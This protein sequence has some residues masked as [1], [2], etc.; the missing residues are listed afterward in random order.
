MYSASIDEIIYTAAHR[1][2][3]L[4][5]GASAISRTQVYPDCPLM[6]SA[7]IKIESS[8]PMQQGWLNNLIDDHTPNGITDA[9]SFIL[10]LLIE[11]G[12]V[13]NYA[14]S[15]FL[16]KAVGLPFFFQNSVSK[17]ARNQ[18]GCKATLANTDASI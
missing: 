2:I 14:Y 16:Q 13:P 7:I 8:M 11:A 17:K 10:D 1:Q 15:N 9:E 12:A 3:R 5:R 4:L 18:F 6:P